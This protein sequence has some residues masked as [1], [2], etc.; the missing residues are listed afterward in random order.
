LRIISWLIGTSFVCLIIFLLGPFVFAGLDWTGPGLDWPEPMS[1]ADPI[2]EDAQIAMPTRT[3]RTNCQ[4][5]QIMNSVPIYAVSL[6]K[7]EIE[8]A[9]QEFGTEAAQ[10]D[11][12]I[13][14]TASPVALILSGRNAIIWNL[15][16]VKGARVAAI[17][18][19]GFDRQTVVSTQ[20]AVGVLSATLGDEQCKSPLRRAN[21][22]Q[23]LEALTE[24]ELR[25]L[26]VKAFQREPNQVIAKRS[27]DTITIGPEDQ[28]AQIPASSDPFVVP[29][30]L[31]DHH[32]PILF[33]RPALQ[34]LVKE[35]MLTQAT[36][37]DI[38]QWKG[39]GH[40]SDNP[41]SYIKEIDLTR[42]FVV[43]RPFQMPPGVK[44]MAASAF[45]LLP[46]VQAPK[47][48]S[49]AENVYLRATPFG[50]DRSDG[51]YEGCS[52]VLSSKFEPVSYPL[53]SAP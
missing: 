24:L 14:E 23:S 48:W 34:R 25:Q 12:L 20:T 15:R 27:V 11:V 52:K 19:T 7:G 16:L 21:G 33:G 3:L 41:P 13:T 32:R 51:W 8:T 28:V 29:D 42:A 37:D 9:V 46:G 50:C 40:L 17:I 6:R 18:T 2:L 22:L 31:V 44:G 5:P 53:K 4:L 26:S 39:Y 10:V 30:T 43:R 35:G 49:I 47:A 1:D 36:A 38:A 45:I